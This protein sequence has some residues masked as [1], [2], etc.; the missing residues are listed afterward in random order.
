MAEQYTERVG[1]AGTGNGTATRSWAGGGPRAAKALKRARNWLYATGAVAM[2][3]GA[4]AIIIP[5]AA[6]VT[7][8][9]LIGWIL[10][11]VGA[12][13][14]AHAWSVRAPGRGL[15]IFNAVL[16]ALA[17][18]SLIAFPLTGTFTL[19]FF[20][21]AFFLV[22]GAINLAAAIAQRDE[23]G[24]LM[25][26]LHGA[27]SLILGVLIIADLPSSADWAIGLLV[28]VNL[29]FFAVRCFAAAAF[30][31][32]ARKAVAGRP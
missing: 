6:S 11:V 9:I 26:G 12:F 24:A 29:I 28:G 4:L 23:P 7:V 19:T 1:S 3:A 20:L 16:M 13:A 5:A 18:I 22:T 32:T 25:L 2:V 15:R 14:L 17:G 31:D 21:A 10:L 27:V 8:A 30:I